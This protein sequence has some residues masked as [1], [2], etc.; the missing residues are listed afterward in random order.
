MGT[1]S[2]PIKSGY[3]GPNG[4]KARG[5]PEAESLFGNYRELW[6]LEVL[7]PFFKFWDHFEWEGEKL[8]LFHLA[9]AKGEAN[10]GPTS[11]GLAGLAGATAHRLRR[12]HE[13][14]NF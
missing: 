9:W 4:A 2:Y 13:R 7:F 8:P 3:G 14:V 10:R 1:R 6:L 11:V 5:Q 12:V